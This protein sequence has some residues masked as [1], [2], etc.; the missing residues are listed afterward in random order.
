LIFSS[1]VFRYIFL[2]LTF[3][4]LFFFFSLFPVSLYF[5]IYSFFFV[6]PFLRFY[7]LRLIQLV[8][9]HN[10]LVCLNAK[11]K[12]RIRPKYCFRIVSAENIFKRHRLLSM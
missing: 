10:T 11:L 7:S 12:L 9:K 5:L 4:F 3:F 6:R 1:S 2:T 8:L